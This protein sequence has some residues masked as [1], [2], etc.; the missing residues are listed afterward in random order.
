MRD[1]CGRGLHGA[2][3]NVMAILF[4]DERALFVTSNVERRCDVSK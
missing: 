3:A 1:A 4:E 2:M